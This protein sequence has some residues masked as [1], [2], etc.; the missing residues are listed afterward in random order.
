MLG[1]ELGNG[2]LAILDSGCNSDTHS[3]KAVKTF[4]PGK[5]RTLMEPITFS[6]AS[7][8]ITCDQGCTVKYGP[9][10]L[11]IDTSLSPGDNTPSLISIGQRVMDAG[12]SFFWIAGKKPCMITSC[13]RYIVIFEVSGNV[14]VYAP[15]FESLKNVFLGTFYLTDNVFQDRCGLQVD[16][17]GNVYSMLQMP[18]EVL[19]TLLPNV[20]AGVLRPTESTTKCSKAKAEAPAAVPAKSPSFQG[21]ACHIATKA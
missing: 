14:P 17:K 20:A 21:S 15:V 18:P 9:W 13:M 4:R 6:T 10:D 2:R 5:L 1:I 7:T 19:S 16:R 12:M 11:S 3:L 8:P